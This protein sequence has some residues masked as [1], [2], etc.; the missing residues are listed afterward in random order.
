MVRFDADEAVVAMRVPYAP[1]FGAGYIKTIGAMG[2]A[3]VVKIG[4]SAKHR[5][6]ELLEIAGPIGLYI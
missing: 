6:L 4:L 3:A 2:H 1:G 5:P